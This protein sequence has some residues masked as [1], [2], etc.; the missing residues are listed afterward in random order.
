MIIT[1]ETTIEEYEAFLA[2][3]PSMS[4]LRRAMRSTVKFFH[5]AADRF[6]NACS[7]IKKACNSIIAFAK[8]IYKT[9]LAIISV[10]EEKKPYQPWSHPMYLYEQVEDEMGMEHLHAEALELLIKN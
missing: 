9:C 2:T 1:H 6:K 8:K 5:E 7:S 4:I 10:E 3:N